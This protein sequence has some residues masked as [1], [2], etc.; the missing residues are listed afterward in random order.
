M[1]ETLESQVGAALLAHGW[2]ISTAESCTGGLVLHRLTNIP[3]S[4]AYVAG[5]IVAYSNSV[6]QTVLRVKQGTL[7]AHGA[8]SEQTALEM[9]AGVRQL[10][11]TDVAVSITGIAG[12]GGGTSEKPVGLTYIALAGPDDLLVVQRHIWDG[13]RLAVKNASAE[14]ALQLVLDTLNA[15]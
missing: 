2:T 6:K 12:P 3:G 5:G 10:L 11:K 1:S 7:L 15:A 13:D 8:V 4:S 9:A 14:A